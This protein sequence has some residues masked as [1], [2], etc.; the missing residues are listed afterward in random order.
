MTWGFGASG[1]LGHGSTLSYQ[2]PR[3]VEALATYC[4]TYIE[5]GAYHNAALTSDGAVFTWGRGDVN[6]LGVK[7]SKMMKDDM[8]YASLFPKIVEDLLQVKVCQ[9]ACGE[10]H[11]MA[12]DTDGNVH[13]FGW[14]EDG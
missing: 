2:E 11:T 12:L 14:G 4:I 7:Q 9:V 5:A 8:G 3:I 13:S 1:V 10:A 6:Q